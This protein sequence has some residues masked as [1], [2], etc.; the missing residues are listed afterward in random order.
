ML[1]RITI[2]REKAAEMLIKLSCHNEF[3]QLLPDG[4]L[5]QLIR[6]DDS[7]DGAEQVS[8]EEILN[9]HSQPLLGY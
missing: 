7:I 8:L 3:V 4:R 6:L 5:V 1:D 2:G 9:V